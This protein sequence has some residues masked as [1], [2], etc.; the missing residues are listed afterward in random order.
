LYV[1]HTTSCSLG[2][3]LCRHATSPCVPDTRSCG[4]G[5][6]LC[7]RMTCARPPRRTAEVR[8]WQA[9]DEAIGTGGGQDG[10]EATRRHFEPAAST[11]RV[12]D[13]QQRSN[14]ARRPSDTPQS[15]SPAAQFLSGCARIMSLDAPPRSPTDTMHVTRGTSPVR[16]CADTCAEHTASLQP[17]ASCFTRDGRRVERRAARLARHGDARHRPARLMSASSAR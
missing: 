16:T 5:P 14:G 10:D 15:R 17:F 2:I 8:C 3:A 1:G 9:D 11:H 7:T 12:V 6:S 13:A 4:A